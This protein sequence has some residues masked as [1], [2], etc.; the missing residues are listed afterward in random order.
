[1]EGSSPHDQAPAKRLEI[2]SP[3]F[4]NG[5]EIPPQYTCRGQ[6]VNP[7]LNIFNPPEGTQ[8]LTLIMHDPDAVSGDFLHWLVWDIPPATE[9]IGVNS[10]PVGAVQG[11]NG[12]GQPGYTGPCPPNGTGKHRYIFDFYA[13]DTTLDLPANSDIEAVIKAQK[14]HM[15]DTCSLTGTFSAST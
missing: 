4:R 12:A 3:V 10:V 13:L 8:S 1:M 2:I 11:L 15:L 14:G 6:N 5:G 7:P 9:S